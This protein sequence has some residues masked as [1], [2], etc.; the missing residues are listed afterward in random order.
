MRLKK[1]FVG[2]NIPKNIEEKLMFEVQNDPEI[3]LLPIKWMPDENL[4]I[5][6]EFLGYADEDQSC[7]I[8][9]RLHSILKDFTPFPVYFDKITFGP[10]GGLPEMVWVTGPENI[11]LKE[12]NKKIISDL[13]DM[14]LLKKKTKFEFSM[15]IN[16]GRQSRQDAKN[17]SEIYEK[18]I[19]VSFTV[20]EIALMESFKEKNKTR[21]A[22]FENVKLR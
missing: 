13:S 10:P 17:I 22:I 7:E 15:H 21:Y 5:T 16:M 18:K 9:E 8:A 4:H 3:A 11:F 14:C 19:K 20:S 2:I 12:L 6:L 1:L